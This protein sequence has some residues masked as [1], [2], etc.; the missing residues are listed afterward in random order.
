MSPIPERQQPGLSRSWR[1]LQSKAADQRPGKT[2]GLLSL[3]IAVVAAV[4]VYYIFT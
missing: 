2:G 3:Y 4:A 1:Y